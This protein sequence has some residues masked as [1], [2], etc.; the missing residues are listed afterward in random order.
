MDAIDLVVLRA[1]HHAAFAASLRRYISGNEGFVRK[2]GHLHEAK[3]NTSVST[4]RSI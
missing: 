4:T 3:R 2:S 1:P